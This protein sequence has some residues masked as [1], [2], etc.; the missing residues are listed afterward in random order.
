MELFLLYTLIAAAAYWIWRYRKRQIILQEQAERV[1]DQMTDII[2]VVEDSREQQAVRARALMT[3][4]NQAVEEFRKHLNN[5]HG[6]FSNHQLTQWKEQHGA[7]Y[8]S[9][10][11]FL[12]FMSFLTP[13]EQATLDSFLFYYTGGDH[14]RSY[15]NKAFAEQE[16]K[17]YNTFFSNIEGRRLDDQQRTAIVTDED[18][19]LVIAGAGSGKTTTIVG[20]VRYILDRYKVNPEEIL[21]ISFTKNAASTL[22]ERI[23]VKGIDAKT[24]HKLGKDIIVACEAKQPSIFDEAQFRPLIE[25]IFRELMKQPHYLHQV[26]EYFTNYLKPAKSAFDFKDQ[27]EYIQ[28]LKDQNFKTYKAKSINRNGK[29]TYRMEVV[30]SIEECRIANFLLFHNVSYA[31]E[32]PYEVETATDSYRQ[33]RPDFT[34][35]QGEKKIYLEH[36]GI[37]RDGRVPDWFSGADGQT[38]S[39]KYLADM[40]WK[41]ALHQQHGTTLLESFSYEMSEGDL[42]D[43]LSAKLQE[44]GIELKP[45]T[46]AEIWALISEVAPDETTTFLTLIQT[47]ITLMK[48]NN[49][50]IDD[51]LQKNRQTPL[52]Y[53]RERNIAFLGILQPIYEA[54]QSHL[55]NRNEIDF[56][57]MINLATAHV[58]AGHYQRKLSYIIIDEFQDI[59]IGRYKLI[60]ALQARN[61]A[62]KLFCVGDDW[63]SIYRFSGSDLALFKDYEKYFGFTV[64]SKIETTYRFHP[65]LIG[66]SSRFILKN[67]NQTPKTLRGNSTLKL[68]TYKII[69]NETDNQ[70]DTQTLQKV[71]NEL[72]SSITDIEKKEIL[73]LGRYGFDLDRVKNEEN[74]FTIDRHKQTLAYRIRI[75]KEGASETKTL[76]AQFMTVHKSKGLEG[77]IVIVLNCNSGKMGFPAEMSDDPVL[78]LL[79]SESDQYPNGEERRLFYVAMTRARER[80]YLIA[81]ASYKSKF[82]ME[83][84]NSTANATVSKCP[85][86]LTADVMVMKTGT[87]KNG[88]KY[89]FYGCTNYQY[90]CNYNKTEWFN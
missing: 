52:R 69:Y 39:E 84:E 81:D 76:T 71:F 85:R 28:Y 44:A 38:A 56:S 73:L 90:G 49:H 3:D 2:Q 10:R 50:S 83:F 37:T 22:A 88:N 63:Q 14:Q 7:L 79:L 9:M 32:H 82:I 8:K 26:T 20:K 57:D 86:C 62:C 58:N 31:Y 5:E 15:H 74:I 33:Y 43:N 59:S 40:E 47:F 67:P 51:L 6:Y 78:N 42:F 27:G 18:N 34:I 19:N 64:R 66:L 80:L 54:Y 60:A 1:S 89:K 87:A 65:P 36:F 53:F 61:P 21:L 72:A 23:N 29:L 16:L 46:E 25:R 4:I 35:T 55:N 11:E 17:T 12:A 77:D 30:K 68:T 41:R 70:D 48:S 75:D 24:F 45:M 13:E